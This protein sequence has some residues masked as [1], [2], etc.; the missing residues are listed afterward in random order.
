M[1]KKNTDGPSPGRTTK[2]AKESKPALLRAAGRLRE[3]KDAFKRLRL[4]AKAAKRD[5][6]AARKTLKKLRKQAEPKAAKAVPAAKSKG[7][8]KVKVKDKPKA[9]RKASPKTSA[10]PA[11]AK[12][13]G[14]GSPPRRARRTSTA[15]HSMPTSETP[16]EIPATP[17]DASPA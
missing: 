12:T 4:L 14:S 5:V 6:K 10:A 7:K 16:S 17:L 1:E 13:N 15:E 8:P 2:G 3:A 9:G 11:A